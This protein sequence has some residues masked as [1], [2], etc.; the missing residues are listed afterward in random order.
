MN[1]DGFLDNDPKTPEAVYQSPVRNAG[2]ISLTVA[3][4]NTLLLNED[5]SGVVDQ[6]QPAPNTGNVSGFTD[7]DDMDIFLNK[8]YLSPTEIDL[9]FI[10]EEQTRDVTIFSLYREPI[11]VLDIAK[12]NFAGAVLQHDPTPFQL[13]ANSEKVQDLTIFANGQPFQ[14]STATYT[15]DSNPGD[16]FVLTITGRRILPFLYE[17]N[18]DTFIRR[19]GFQ[20]IL[21]SDEKGNE[22]RRSISGYRSRLEL[23]FDVQE[24]GINAQKLRNDLRRF[25]FSVLGVP[26]FIEAMHINS[27]PQNT[28]VIAVNEDFSYFYNLKNVCDFILIKNLDDD[29]IHEIKQIASLD[30]INK[31]INVLTTVSNSYDVNNTVVYPVLLS[32][33]EKPQE[34]RPTEDI[35]EVSF[36][37]KEFV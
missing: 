32:Y 6:T 15:V 7:V 3:E 37:F 28:Q 20:T 12:A 14:N 1:Q 29:K 2:D 5:I 25:S 21:Y 11:Q 8:F 16:E 24:N 13:N 35:L 26:I 36:N 17:A 18:F 23:Q 33:M 9:G 31:E 22:Q 4:T 27:D 34:K 30:E 10:T 19:Y